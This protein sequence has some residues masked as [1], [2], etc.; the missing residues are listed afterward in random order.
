[1]PWF[2]RKKPPRNADREALK[3]EDESDL[4]FILSKWDISNKLLLGMELSTLWRLF[5]ES[6]GSVPEF[7]RMPRNA[8]MHYLQKLLTCSAEAR[9]KSAAIEGAPDAGS[10]DLQC[11][12]LSA[13]FLAS[14]V[15]CLME[16][17]QEWEDE[18]APRLDQLLDFGWQL[19]FASLPLPSDDRHFPIHDPTKPHTLFTRRRR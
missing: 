15:I 18:L 13:R 6:F 3:N 12:S 5:L 19:S 2:G 9:S 10:M 1:M 8:Q 17:D 4:R 11:E 7:E 14:Y 16:K